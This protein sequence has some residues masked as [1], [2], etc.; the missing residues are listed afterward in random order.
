MISA[1]N[2]QPFNDSI[3]LQLLSSPPGK[4]PHLTRVVRFGGCC[5]LAKRRVCLA[6]QSCLNAIPA[7]WLIGG[8]Q[9]WDGIW[10]MDI[11]HTPH[12]E[13][14]TNTFKNS[15]SKKSPFFA[16]YR[17]EKWF[18]NFAYLQPGRARQKSWAWPGRNI[19]Q[20]RT[21]FFSRLCTSNIFETHQS[22]FLYLVTN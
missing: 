10:Y 19:S 20:P 5:S 6:V 13:L 4:I 18:T 7:T 8:S 1:L 22:L 2:F 11:Q 17:A 3:T 9:S 12:I 15:L 21:N 14:G 16:M